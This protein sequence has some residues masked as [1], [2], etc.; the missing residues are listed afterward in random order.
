MKGGAAIIAV[1]A[2]IAAGV[3]G[4]ALVGQPQLP[5][6]PAPPVV[7]NPAVRPAAE[8]ASARLLQNHG[9]VRAWLT[10][11]D[12]LIREGQTAAAVDALQSALQTA[13]DDVNLWVQLGVALVAHAE[14][15]VVPAAR[16]AFDRASQRDPEHPA[17][18]FYLGLSWLQ[19]GAATRALE[20]WQPLAATAPAD[21]PWKATL[22][23][24]IEMAQRM[25]QMEGG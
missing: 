5:A 11:S 16:L 12:A 23:R 4:Y 2:A 24:H 8:Q 20:V 10:L 25:Q 22:D 19:A 13:P 18:Q 17:P 14:G 9:D 6:A 15:E 7:V 1:L 21:A 3:I